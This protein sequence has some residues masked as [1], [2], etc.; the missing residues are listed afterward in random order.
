MS[1]NYEAEIYRGGLL[2]TI[3]VKQIK[4]GLI[5]VTVSTKLTDEETGKIITDSA[6]TWF[7]EEKEF[8]EFFSPF[9]NDMKVRIENATDSKSE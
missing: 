2:R 9:I 5:E 8:K 3:K 4:Y 1:L 6:H 7:F